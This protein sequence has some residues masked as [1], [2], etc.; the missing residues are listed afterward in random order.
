ME[1]EMEMTEAEEQEYRAKM[2]EVSERFARRCVESTRR[3]EID[4]A[5]MT[6]EMAMR[7]HRIARGEQP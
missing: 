4:E 6:L 1:T 7:A 3:G 5:L 2:G